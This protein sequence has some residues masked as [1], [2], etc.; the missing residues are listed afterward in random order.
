V[1]LFL[2][3]VFLY[4][5]VC[6]LFGVLFVVAVVMR[7]RRYGWRTQIEALAQAPYNNTNKEQTTAYKNTKRRNSKAHKHNTTQHHTKQQ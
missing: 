7:G 5:V 6:S 4:A 3:L 1:L 2:R